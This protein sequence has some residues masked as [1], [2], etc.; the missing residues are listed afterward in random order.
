MVVFGENQKFA[1][2]LISPDMEFLKSW[3]KGHEVN[4]TT[5]AEAIKDPVVLKRFSQ[6]VEKYN[7]F[8]GETEK[9]KKFTLICDEWSQKT[10]ILT[11]TLKVKRHVIKNLYKEQI[12]G[13]FA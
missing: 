8:F 11:P 1:A 13:L 6:E 9:V 12:D 5:A 3:C 4:F 2:A 7:S 10:G